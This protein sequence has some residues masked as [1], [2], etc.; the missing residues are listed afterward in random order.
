MGVRRPRSCQ[1][2]A[3]PFDRQEFFRKQ[4]EEC[5]ELERHAVT[6]EDRAFWQQTTK[7]WE[8]QLR[9]A[10]SQKPRKPPQREHTKRA[11]SEDSAEA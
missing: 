4:I 6:A 11:L 8:E 3:M 1:A 7:R 9:L 5:R 2:H 10:E